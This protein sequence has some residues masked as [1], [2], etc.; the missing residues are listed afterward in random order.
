[1]YLCS[2]SVV[3]LYV[4]T[5]IVPLCMYVVCVY[6]CVSVC[7]CVIYVCVCNVVFMCNVYL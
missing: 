3:C 4:Y 1:M 2:V 7:I 5:G 6:A